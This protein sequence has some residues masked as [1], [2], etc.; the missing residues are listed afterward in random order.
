MRNRYLFFLILFSAISSG[1]PLSLGEIAEYPTEN[2]KLRDPFKSQLP[3]EKPV[4]IAPVVESDK[5]KVIVLPNF[6]V[7]GMIWDSPR[8]LAIIDN[9]VLKIGDIIQEAK[10]IHISK[11][12]IDLIYQGKLF[13]IS[14]VS[15]ITKE[16]KLK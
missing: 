6:T 13:T 5:E 4:E 1:L 3:T 14:T 8:P 2:Y 16:G 7:Q 12:G 15:V 11:N 10:V 9:K